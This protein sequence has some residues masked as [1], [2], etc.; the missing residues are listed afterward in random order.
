MS[1]P[2]EGSG[3][4]NEVV[5]GGAQ[6]DLDSGRQRVY[7]KVVEEIIGWCSCSGEDGGTLSYK[8]CV[9]GHFGE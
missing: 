7:A 6:A 3:G 9:Q 8:P 5:S 4:R 2:L 1:Q